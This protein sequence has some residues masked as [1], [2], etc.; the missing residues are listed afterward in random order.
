M[1]REM[2]IFGP[3]AAIVL[4]AATTWA[5]RI[6]RW[7]EESATETFKE[8]VTNVVKEAF[9]P[10]FLHLENKL[11]EV[12]AQNRADHGAVAGRMAAVEDQ[13][14]L[15]KDELIDVKNRLKKL[16]VAVQK[17]NS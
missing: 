4:M 17:E 7:L 6:G 9:A 13:L 2:L 3:L 10:R 11:D 14:A 12:Q 8:I 1:M 15:A 16:E 5:R